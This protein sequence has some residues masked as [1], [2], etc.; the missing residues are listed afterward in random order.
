MAII[1]TKIE[2]LKAQLDEIHKDRVALRNKERELRDTITKLEAVRDSSADDN[3]V[4][5]LTA[6]FEA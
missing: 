2:E 5:E 3:Y 1:D 4:T 6:P